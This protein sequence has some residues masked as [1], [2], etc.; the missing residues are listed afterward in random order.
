M[1]FSGLGFGQN[2]PQFVY[3][4]QQQQPGYPCWYPQQQQQG[5]QQPPQPSSPQQPTGDVYGLLG[6]ILQLLMSLLGA[7]ETG[8]TVDS[9]SGDSSEVTASSALEALKDNSKDFDLDEDGTIS[10]GELEEIADDEDADQYL[11]LVA[12]FLISS[13][14]KDAYDAIS[15]ES[16]EESGIQIEGLEDV[17]ANSLE[18]SEEADSEDSED[19][20]TMSSESVVEMLDKHKYKFDTDGDDTVTLK[21]LRD[22]ADDE[23]ED[24]DLREMAEFLTDTSEGREIF[25]ALVSE[26]DGT[27][28]I[29][30]KEVDDV[31]P[32]KL[33]G[34]E[35]Y[36]SQGDSG[37]IDNSEDA[38]DALEDDDL[39]EMLDTSDVDGNPNET[40]DGK[41]SRA[42][43]EALAEGK[44]EFGDND[45]VTQEQRDAAA[46]ILDSENS[47][48]EESLDI[49]GDKLND[50]MY[51]TT[52]ITALLDDGDG[53]EAIDDG[54][55]PDSLKPTS[56]KEASVILKDS[57]LEAKLHEASE[58]DTLDPSVF[59]RKA[60]EELA[61]GEG[62]FSTA[63]LQQRAAAQHFLDNTT[64]ET[65]LDNQAGTPD[66]D[67]YLFS[68]FG[69]LSA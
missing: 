35:N 5:W 17:D 6:G 27:D 28:G 49:Q 44:G 12:D 2:Y 41:Y 47:V 39:L 64:D 14:G 16:G 51:A 9:G 33:P 15:Q 7:P 60:L 45:K 42:A 68:S 54:D 40:D 52:S 20:V 59:N 48:L 61:E 50:D 46:Y 11:R 65:T 55:L 1:T 29:N 63:T 32:D 57:G 3:P 37:N 36:A 31:N 19:A 58:D 30:I 22:I 4:Q 13:K 34:G 18:E 24:S 23:D 56:A 66:D 21:E 26:T 43:L 25:E 10:K 62:D 8:G 53:L 67:E 69:A 38:L